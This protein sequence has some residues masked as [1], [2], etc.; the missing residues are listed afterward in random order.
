MKLTLL[1]WRK[2]SS[3]LQSLPFWIALAYPSIEAEK[4]QEGTGKLLY[5]N[6][7]FDVNQGGARS[8]IFLQ[9]K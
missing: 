4:S 5:V 3:T 2:T 9:G 1:K 6:Q 8:R 7:W